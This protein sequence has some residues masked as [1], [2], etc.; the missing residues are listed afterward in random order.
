MKSEVRF[1]RGFDDANSN[2][3]QALSK[4]IV[5]SPS[6][7]L[8]PLRKRDNLGIVK[9]GEFFALQVA[10]DGVVKSESFNRGF[11]DAAHEL[12]PG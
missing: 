4:V 5:Q 2:W 1:N 7:S 12:P 8:V 10:E 3:S 11:D 6:A 9:A